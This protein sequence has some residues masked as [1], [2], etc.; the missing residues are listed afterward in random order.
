[1]CIRDRHRPLLGFNRHEIE[2]LATKIG[3]YP[4]PAEKRKVCAVKSTKPEKVIKLQ[5][6][7]EAEKRLNVEEMIDRSIKSLKAISL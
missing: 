5:E 2:E 4:L 6:I 7:I 1:M 3:I